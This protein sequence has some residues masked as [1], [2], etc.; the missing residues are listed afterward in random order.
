MADQSLP[1]AR[2]LLYGE[3]FPTIASK[4]ADL[5]RGLAKNLGVAS[6]PAKRLCLGSS[7]PLN[8]EKP[9]AGSYSKYN[10]RPKKKRL[11]SFIDNWRA[12][13]SDPGILSIVLGYKLQFIIPVT[14][15]NQVNADLIDSEVENFLTK[16]AL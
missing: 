11:D 6:Q 12:I 8:R 1:N 2:R 3:D 13:T 5:S 10:S 14:S 16:G 4:E 15:P 7:R 9:F